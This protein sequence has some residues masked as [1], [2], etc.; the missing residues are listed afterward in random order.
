MKKFVDFVVGLVSAFGLGVMIGG[1]AA[2]VVFGYRISSK[3]LGN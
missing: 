1:F 2:I 3:L